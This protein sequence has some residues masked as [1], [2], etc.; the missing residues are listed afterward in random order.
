MDNTYAVVKKTNDYTKF[1]TLKG[2]RIVARTR[3]EKIIASIK[4]VGYVMNPIIVNERMEVIDGQGRLEAL[5]ELQLPVY[6]LI[7]PKAGIRECVAMNINQM[8]WTTI[9]YIRSYAERGNENYKALL[10]AIERF[11]P[12]VPVRIIASVCANNLSYINDKELKAGNFEIK[13]WDWESVLGYLSKYVPYKRL[14][15]GSWDNLMKVLQWVYDSKEVDRNIMYEQF[16]KYGRTAIGSISTTEDALD[17]LES[18]YNYR[19]HGHTYLK[20]PYDEAVK[21]K[22]NGSGLAHRR[23]RE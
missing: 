3:V 1:H 9:D 6:Y 12:G 18:V 23:K 2:N 20:Q 19:K 4:E 17:A 22:G 14:V 5:T 13:R 7:V 15:G 16:K 10:S 21:K 8:Q 11:N